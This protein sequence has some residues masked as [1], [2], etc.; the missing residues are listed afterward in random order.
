MNVVSDMR[1]AHPFKDFALQYWE[2]GWFPLPLPPGEKAPPPQGFTGYHAPPTLDDINGWIVSEP[3]AANIG[4][5]V[6]DGLIGI[7]VDAYSGKQGGVGLADLTERFGDLPPAW[8]LSARSDGISGIRFYRIPTG[9]HWPGEIAPDVQIVQFRYRFAVA[10]PS[11]HPKIRKV[12]KWYE[13]G[14]P[15]DGR[16]WTR[17]IPDVRGLAGVQAA[18]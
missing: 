17:D 16:S 10:Y 2:R 13:P 9:K 6:P 15:I 5:R 8:T 4:V 11:L 7:D 1:S 18:S 14:A 12:Y 3:D